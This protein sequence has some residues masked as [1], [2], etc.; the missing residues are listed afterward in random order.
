[1]SMALGTAATAIVSRAFGAGTHDEAVLAN[2]KCLSLS[3][4]TGIVLAIIGLPGALAASLLLVPADNAEVRS[5][6]VLYASIFSACL[7]AVF[8]I[9]SLAGALRGIGDTKSPMVIS[10]LQIFL[11]IL[12]NFLLVLPPRDVW[13]AQVWGAGWGLAGAGVSMAASS[14]VAAFVYIAWSRRTQLETKLDWRLPEMDW[15]RRILRIAL[16]HSR[17]CSSTRT[18]PLTPKGRSAQGSLSS[19]SRSCPRSDSLSLRQPSWAKA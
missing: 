1:M 7:P 8:V 19:R 6:F 15:V 14:W 10:G 4:L 13:G 17:S 11:H 5:Q 2:S 16:P 3:I 18:T 9:Q 12:L